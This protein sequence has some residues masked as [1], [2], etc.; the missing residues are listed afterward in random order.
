MTDFSDNWSVNDSFQD[1]SMTDNSDTWSVNDSFQDNSLTD[2][3]LDVDVDVSD[4]NV[5]SPTGDLND[6][7][8]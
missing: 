4:I 3:S 6:I 8:F 7:A 2:Q 5:G 1:N